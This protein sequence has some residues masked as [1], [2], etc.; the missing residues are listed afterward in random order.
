[1]KEPAKCLLTLTEAVKW[2]EGL[3]QSG[4]R[5][6]VTNGCF[7]LV[8]R[9]HASY[10]I[11][12]AK[13]GDELLVLINSDA[14][15]RS[16]KGESRPVVS[17]VD[18]AYLILPAVIRNWRHCSRIFTPKRGITRWKLWILARKKHCSIAEQRSFSCPLSMVFPPPISWKRSPPVCAEFSAK[19]K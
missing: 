11:E 13:L 5:L 17:E 12:A 2:R 1:M 6:V 15:V 16:L 9:G 10:L 18:R 8:H 14:S 7:D 3:R 4:K 19:G